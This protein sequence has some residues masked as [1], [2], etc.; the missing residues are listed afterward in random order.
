M[1]D[2]NYWRIK[3]ATLELQ[4]AQLRTTLELAKAGQL[5]EATLREAGLDPDQAYRLDDARES[6]ELVTGDQGAKAP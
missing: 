1:S 5:F 4:N 3:A 6:I 2:V